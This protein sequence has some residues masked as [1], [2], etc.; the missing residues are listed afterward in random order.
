M[1]FTSAPKLEEINM[2]LIELQMRHVFRT[3]GSVRH[4]INTYSKT[5]IKV[6]DL[7]KT[8]VYRVI[9]ELVS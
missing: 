2:S 7:S 5:F 4:G 1:T 6:S 9:K 8:K 3:I